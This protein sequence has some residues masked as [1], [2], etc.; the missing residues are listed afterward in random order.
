MKKALGILFSLLFVLSLTVTVFA[1]SENATI[2]EKNGDYPDPEHPGLRVRVFVHE[3]KLSK[4]SLFKSVSLV[5]PIEDPDSA[6]VVT[7][8]G[9]KLPANWTYTLNTSGVP[10]S[11]GAKNLATIANNAFTGWTNAAGGKVTITKTPFNT[12][13]NRAKLDGQNI[14]AWGKTSSNALAVTYTWYYPSTGLSAEEDTIF[15]KSY[16]WFWNASNTACTDSNSYD[17]QDI[18]THEL[19]HWMGLNDIYTADYV[20]NTMYGYGSM[21]EVKKDTLTTGDIQGVQAIYPL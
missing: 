2:P 14:I 21:G 11:V 19:G 10:S 9:W 7:P 20:N 8:A 4:P 12:T 1:Q 13:V 16:P 5:C 6:A 3:P 17:A 15:N 18:L